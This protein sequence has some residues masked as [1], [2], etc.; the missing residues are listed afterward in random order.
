MPDREIFWNIPFGWII[1]PLGVIAVGVLVYGIFQSYRRWRV[2]APAYRA[3]HWAKRTWSILSLALFDLVFHRKF[4]GMAGGSGHTGLLPADLRPREWGPGLLHFFIFSSAIVF[5]LASFLDAVSHYFFHFLQGGAYLVY[6]AVVDSFGILA[7][8]GA[9]LVIIR[10]CLMRPGRLDNRPDDLTAILIILVLL[11]TGFMVEGF[12]IAATELEPHPDWAPWSP[13]GYV[14]ALAFSGL[15]NGT[16]LTWH[17]VTWWFHGLLALGA[18]ALVPLYQS[19]LL[20]ILWDPVN[21]FFRKLGPPGALTPLD[22]EAEGALGATRI[23]DFT[24][25]QLLDL[26]ACTRCGRCQ[27]N[28]PAYLSGKALSPKKL[29]QDLKTHF[30]QVYPRP[31]PGLPLDSRPDMITQAVTAEVIWDCTSCRACEQACPV[32]IE[33]VDKVIDMRRSLAMES[34]QL[35]AEVQ[36][37]LTSLEVR[38]HPWRGTTLARTDWA[39][40]L[41]VKVLA[42]DS[43]VD[44]LYWVGCTAALEDRNMK[45][46][47]ATARVLAAAGVNFGILGQ[48]ESCCG[49]PARRLGN[50]YLFQTMCRQNIEVLKGYGVKKVVTSC[51][52]C[53][54]TLKHEYPQ[55]GGAFEVVHHTRLIAELIGAGR[56]K[57]AGLAGEMVAYHDSCYLGR[58]NGIYQDPRQIVRAMGVKPVELAHPGEWGLFCGGGGGHMWMEE[59]PEKRV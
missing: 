27:D 55:F 4:F 32:Y 37:T 2:G 8:V 35:P 31:G 5:L 1:Y 54:N 7:V 22:F 28:C 30:Y 18:I 53:F 45:V 43:Q 47:V 14:L 33:H 56:L 38:G 44:I 46:A 26:D 40:G 10:R 59:P 29:I 42:E 6:S 51:P 15:S 41:G 25:K 12:R 9:L 16:I 34:A 39:A 58:Y 3:D 19:K 57:P 11:I 13:G 50:E 52:H 17:A 20:H 48:E 49:D 36:E 21:V 24:W 23:E